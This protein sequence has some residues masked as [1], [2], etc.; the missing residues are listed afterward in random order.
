MSAAGDPRYPVRMRFIGAMAVLVALAGCPTDGPAPANTHLNHDLSA[1]AGYWDAPWP[2]EHRRHA[3]GTVDAAGFP[4]PDGIPFVDVMVRLTDAALDG[5]GASSTI[6]FTA[7][8]PLDPATLPDLWGSVEGDAAV[9]LVG[10]EPGS[11]DHGVRVPV[12]VAFAADGGPFGADRML[13]LLPLQGR[14]LLPDT[15]YAAVVTTA[16]TDTGGDPLGPI[17]EELPAAYEDALAELDGLGVP[18]AAIAGLAVFRTQDVGQGM[19]DLL[20]AAGQH[21]PAPTEPWALTDTFDEYC[22]YQTVVPMPVYQEGDPPYLG[23]GGE[24]A[25]DGEGLPELQRYED[26]RLVVTVPRQAPPAGGWPVAV[27]IRTGGGGDRPLVDRGPRAEPGGEAIVPGSGPAGWLTAAGFAGVSVDG[28]HGGLR[29]VTGGD[30]QFLV[31]NVGNPAAMRDN[32]RQS[33]VE[34]ALLPALLDDLTVDALD[35]P[36]AD[37]GAVG[38]DTAHIALIGHSMGATIA[39]TTLA[40]QPRYGAVVLSG[41]GG[42]W[43]HNIMVKLSPLE[44]RPIAEAVLGY[45]EGELTAADPALALLQWSGESADPPPH[46]WGLGHEPGDGPHV[47]MV[48][49]V[50]DT[51]ILPPISN[52]TSLSLGLDL[53]GDPLDADHPALQAFRPFEVV[54]G[55]VGSAVI[56]VPA[57]GNHSSGRTA[58]TV[59][60][61]EDGIED[62]HEALF[63]TDPPRHQ[64][65]CFLSSWLQHGTP[66][67]PVG[68][69][70]DDP[71]DP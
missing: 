7:D 52:A 53:A 23:G 16:V 71:C 66:T 55:L 26:A 2:S 36:G 41:A 14:P 20:A 19:R 47:L 4:N 13:S 58:V 56:P 40:V 32:L 38:F 11:P 37:D 29:N 43:I 68:G 6:Y 61:P 28:P 46:A 42:S 24:I 59:Q 27:F 44:V 12:D 65:R 49:G 39:P 35:C 5:F 57:S 48:Q 3:D 50:V 62:G 15:T 8:G 10:V 25:L 51:Y 67:V 21:P 54:A 22:V 63:Q 34:L 31:F 9:F 70:Y 18:R 17:P 1:G 64:A 45:D 69:A 30:E 60:W 33:A